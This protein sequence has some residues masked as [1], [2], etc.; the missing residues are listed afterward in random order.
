M[1][2]TTGAMI[3]AIRKQDGTFDATPSPN[4][5][6]DPG[7]F[8]IGVGT[9]EEIRRLEQVFAPREAAGVA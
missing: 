7:E 5:G 1:R 4:S 9:R 8:V 2:D 6:F 3:V